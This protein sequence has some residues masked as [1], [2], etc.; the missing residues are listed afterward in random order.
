MTTFNY[1]TAKK[2][3][4]L[5]KRVRTTEWPD[6]TFI[7]FSNDGTYRDENNEIFSFT[8]DYEEDDFVLQGDDECQTQEIFEKTDESGAKV[9]GEHSSKL[10][11]E[12]NQTESENNNQN[13]KKKEM[14]ENESTIDETQQKLM[15]EPEKTTTKT[16]KSESLS[17]EIGLKEIEINKMKLSESTTQKTESTS[18]EKSYPIESVEILSS[19]LSEQSENLNLVQS[20]SMSLID[21]SANHLFGLMK[22]M[23]PNNQ[24]DDY[25]T[26]AKVESS[27]KIARELRCIMK[28]K[29]DTL[30]FA[31]ELK[32]LNK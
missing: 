11:A 10:N 19:D 15:N 22:L 29:L 31:Q 6:D 5:G 1:D 12:K 9:D 26:M 18:S 21:S 27:V 17:E 14:S 28:L 16:E 23:E 2:Y 25:A 24:S 7:Y 32:E 20:Q 13:I 4:S 8:D 30:K 3:L